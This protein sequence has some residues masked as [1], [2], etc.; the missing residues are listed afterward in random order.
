MNMTMEKIGEIL[1]KKIANFEKL[2]AER[3]FPVRPPKKSTRLYI[4]NEYFGKGYAAFFPKWAT[5]VYL[6]LA[7]YANY[8]TQICYPSIK[9]I[10]RESGVSNRNS[11]VNAI[12]VLEAYKI[13]GTWHSKGRIANCYV[14]LSSSIWGEPNSISM[15]TIKKSNSIKKASPTVSKPFF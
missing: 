15:D 5:M 1:S 6:V 2:C 4:D 14:L 12:K 11:V 10:I 9:T 13:I 7:K 3:N 8:R